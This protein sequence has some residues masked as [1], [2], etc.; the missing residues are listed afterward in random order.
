PDI[1]SRLRPCV[2][3]TLVAHTDDVWQPTDPQSCTLTLPGL[4]NPT[5]SRRCSR[6]DMET[7]DI[8][9]SRN[10]PH[11][12]PLHLVQCFNTCRRSGLSP[13]NVGQRGGTNGFSGRIR[14]L[15]PSRWN[16][17]FPDFPRNCV[18]SARQD[19]SLMYVREAEGRRTMRS[20][21]EL[22]DA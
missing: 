15:R 3:R 7:I 21:A 17:P 18:A 16:Q 5:L 2:V 11:W 9:K 20:T 12:T 13:A 4:R 22:V 19:A 6:I 1:L 10:A 14:A 8:G